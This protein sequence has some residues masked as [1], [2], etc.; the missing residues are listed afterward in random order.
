MAGNPRALPHTAGR[1][2]VGE[3]VELELGRDVQLVPPP[4][5][6][7]AS[8]SVG[9]RGAESRPGTWRR[10]VVVVVDVSDAG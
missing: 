9:R 10:F 2:L 5:S 8:V 3:E 7:P 4:R 1:A 6:W